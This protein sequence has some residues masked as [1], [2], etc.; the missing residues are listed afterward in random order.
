MPKKECSPLFTEFAEYTINNHG[1]VT[2]G[3]PFTLEH[4]RAELETW[5]E[6]EDDDDPPWSND[7]LSEVETELGLIEQGKDSDANLLDFVSDD[8]KPD[9]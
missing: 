1:M 4:L 3:D 8:F 2:K 7:D 5:Q 6:D 9:D